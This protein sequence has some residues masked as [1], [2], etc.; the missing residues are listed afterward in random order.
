MIFDQLVHVDLD[1]GESS[2]QNVHQKKTKLVFGDGFLKWKVT[3]VHVCVMR[4]S[5]VLVV[6]V[7][8]RTIYVSYNMPPTSLRFPKLFQR[9]QNAL[10][11]LGSDL[12]YQLL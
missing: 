7:S 12:R 2:I 9:V 8:N 3:N 4:Q 6:V 1:F 5:N 11:L 10:K